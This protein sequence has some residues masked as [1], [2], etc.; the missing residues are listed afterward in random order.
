LAPGTDLD[1]VWSASATTDRDR[2]SL[3]RCLHD[4]QN[5]DRRRLASA[6]MKIDQNRHKENGS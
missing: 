2:K 6:V 5:D 4:G 1:K 3:L